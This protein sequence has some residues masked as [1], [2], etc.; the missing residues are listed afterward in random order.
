M[1]VRAMTDPAMMELL[2]EMNGK[3]DEVLG[4]RERHENRLTKLETEAGYIKLG[5]LIVFSLVSYCASWVF[6]KAFPG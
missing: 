4:G 2:K 1:G 6:K 3:L 5:F